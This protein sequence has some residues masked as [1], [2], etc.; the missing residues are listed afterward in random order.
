[1]AWHDCFAS[2]LHGDG[3]LLQRFARASEIPTHPYFLKRANTTAS[4]ATGMVVY[5][6]GAGGRG[7][8]ACSGGATSSPRETVDPKHAA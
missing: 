7:V 3:A 8:A 1:M 5:V 6:V 2:L 4:T